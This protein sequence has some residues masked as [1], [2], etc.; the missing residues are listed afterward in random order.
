[1]HKLNKKYLPIIKKRCPSSI[2]NC[3]YD[4]KKSWED[5]DKLSKLNENWEKLVGLELSKSCK[6]LKIEQKSL[7]IAV[8]HPQWRQ[9]LIY[10][11]HK[12]KERINKFG[13]NLDEIKITQNYE[14]KTSNKKDENAKIVWENHPCRIKNNNM[15]ICNICNSPAPKGELSRWG[16]CTF[17]WRR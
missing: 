10:Y 17:C 14:V 6:P 15:A 11:K 9:E 13:I 7:I 16:K 8:N 1:M 2:R 5:L 4:F 3:L 12:L